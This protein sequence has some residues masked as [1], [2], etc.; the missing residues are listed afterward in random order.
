MNPNLVSIVPCPD[1]APDT[2]EAALIDVLE[3]LGRLDWVKPGMRIGITAPEGRKD[4]WKG[5]RPPGLLWAG[6]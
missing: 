5:K 6:S 3:P 1:Y 2:C 4:P